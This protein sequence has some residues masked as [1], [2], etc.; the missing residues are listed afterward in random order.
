MSTGGD[1]DSLWCWA[2]IRR[3]FIRA[4]DAHKEL[5]EWRDEWVGGR[6]GALYVAHR[7]VKGAEPASHERRQALERFD[8]VLADMD[9]VRKQQMEGENLH[10]AAQK[11]LRTLDNN[12]AERA[13]RTPVVGRK[14]YSGSVTAWSAKLAGRSWTITH[15]RTTVGTQPAH[16]FHCIPRRLC[17]EQQQTAWSTDI[18]KVSSLDG[19]RG[20]PCGMAGPAA[21]N[22]PA[23]LPTTT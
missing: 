23:A 3:Y 17:G 2:H 6:I 11:V 7:I 4:G 13:I 20:R 10:Y 15:H 12:K 16:L 22:I 19:K 18:D 14:N 1:S 8:A 21:M 9:I 5:R